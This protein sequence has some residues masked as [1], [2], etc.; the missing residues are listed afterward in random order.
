MHAPE[1]IT[2]DQPQLLL[3]SLSLSKTPTMDILLPAMGGQPPSEPGRLNTEAGRLYTQDSLGIP[4]PLTSG[5]GSGALQLPSR[6]GV[7]TSPLL[8]GGFIHHASHRLFSIS[9][10]VKVLKN[11]TI[12]ILQNGVTAE[13]RRGE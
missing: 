4:Q 12:C 8:S 5:A 11:V 2:A 9:C 1:V 6:L 7:R 3:H 13:I 10:W